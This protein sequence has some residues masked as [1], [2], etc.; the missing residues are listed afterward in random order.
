[1]G[2]EFLIKFLY[3]LLKILLEILVGLLE[4]FS[5]ECYHAL[6]GVLWILVDNY[7]CDIFFISDVFS[8]RDLSVV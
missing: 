1:M 5:D 8:V 7:F 4:V 3:F 2:L 6:G